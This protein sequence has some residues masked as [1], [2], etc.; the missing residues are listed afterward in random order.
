[1]AAGMSKSFAGQVALVTGAASG[2]GRATALAFARAGAKVIVADV[3]GDG[4]AGTVA[5]IESV[6]P[7]AA[8]FVRCDVSREADA[9]AVVRAAVD[10]F[11]RLDVAF[12][13]AG[14]EGAQA[15][16]DA[17]SFD[18][19]RRVIDVNLCGVFLMMRE[20]I[21]HLRKTRSGGAIVNCASILGQVGFAGAAAYTAA[22]HGVIGL[23]QTAALDLGSEK[24]RVNAVCPGFIETPMLARAGITSAPEMKAMVAA[25]HPMGR[26]GTADEVA[27]A[28]LWLC[29][30]AASFV[31]G[32]ALMVDG[33]YCAR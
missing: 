23:T 22:K 24:I 28:V 6:S 26:L 5:Q 20:E 3:D 10:Q 11:G 8:R 4:G 9:I 15:S 13:N 27:D 19:F 29:S 1:M 17:L 30:P 32:H 21:A 14:I 33:G 16:I 18:A 7:G 25:M 2:I 31:T 12:N